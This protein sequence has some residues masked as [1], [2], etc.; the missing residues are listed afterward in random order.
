MGKDALR[1]FRVEKPQV[2]WLYIALLHLKKSGIEQDKL[3]DGRKLI[4]NDMSLASEFEVS[5]VMRRQRAL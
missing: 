5:L 1:T 3:E 4:E 2:D